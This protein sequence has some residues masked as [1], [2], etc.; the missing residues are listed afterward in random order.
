MSETTILLEDGLFNGSLITF[1]FGG[2]PDFGLILFYSSSL[3]GENL[4][5][6]YLNY[7]S[8]QFN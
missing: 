4:A 3:L 8:I 2:T 6:I 5:G 1:A 7:L